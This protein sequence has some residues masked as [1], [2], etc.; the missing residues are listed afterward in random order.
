MVN[1][2]N[3]QEVLERDPHTQV[4]T[5]E[6]SDRAQSQSSRQALMASI[7]AWRFFIE[8]MDLSP[9]INPDLAVMIEVA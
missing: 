4:M 1:D 6:M 8:G 5:T 9:D 3:A 2:S 7:R